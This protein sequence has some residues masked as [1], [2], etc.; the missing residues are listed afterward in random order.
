M[1][2][3]T[4]FGVVEEIPAGTV[5]FRRGDRT[6]DFLL[7]LSGRIEIYDD[8]PD[9]EPHVFAAHGRH[10]FAGD[11]DLFNDREILV[12][13]RMAGNGRVV[14]LHRPA[15]RRMMVSEPDVAEVVM[16]AF[17]QRRQGLLRRGQGA[18]VVVGSP[19]LWDTVRVERFLVRNGYPV[20]VVDPATDA[21][22]A[23]GVLQS[24]NL[25]TGDPELPVVVCGQGRI[26]TNPTNRDLG[27]CLGVTE[28]IDAD[29]V[30]DVVVVGAGPAGLAAGVY[31]ASEGLDTLVLETEAPG[32]QAG[33]SSLIENYLGFPTGV[34]GQA[35][36]NRAQTQAQ[37]FG[38]RIA[39]PRRAERLRCGQH[40]FLV[41]LDD[42]TQVSGRSVVVA[43]GARYRD[44]DLPG[45]ARFEGS[46]IHHAATALEAKLCEDGEVVVVGGGNSAG[47]A[48]VFLSRSARHVH[49]LV[50]GEG[51]AATMS[52]YL[53][54]RIDASDRIT[55]HR[56][57]E[58]TELMGERYLH[59]VRW[60]NNS[61]G[62]QTECEAAGVFLMLGA[63]PNSDWLRDGVALDAKGF[64]LT[65]PQL[66]RA[67]NGGD[68]VRSSFE[69]SVP[70][71]FA[72]GDVRS[73]SVKRVASAVGD[74]SVV[75][76]AIHQA[77]VSL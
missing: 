34:S 47:Q 45:R 50:R 38:A 39:V 16:T 69:T 26:L 15:F 21:A 72:V 11:V 40:P 73:G 28:P 75:V 17:V 56:R 61:T 7:V 9:G 41:D 13:G 1:A 71:I 51:L 54:G 43:T 70:G 8:G 33:T 22:G 36:A 30:Y 14:R 77:L 52:E 53:V 62:R 65:G 76:S 6:A 10:Q 49:V 66:P 37:R 32:G 60:R 24:L 35:L 3:V 67:A 44:L 31:G 63:V 58:L 23:L 42:G 20:R 27:V 55:L 25:G 64:V 74:G 4:E 57:T 29:R 2:R 48:A 18:V 12:H 5:V 46:G 68:H 59:R 19:R